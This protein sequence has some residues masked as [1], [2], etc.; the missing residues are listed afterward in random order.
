MKRFYYFPFLQ[1]RAPTNC[2]HF[3]NRIWIRKNIYY[4]VRDEY[5]RLNKY[6]LPRHLVWLWKNIWNNVGLPK[7]NFLC[8]ILVQKK[9]LTAEN[10]E[11]RDMQGS[12]LCVLCCKY[13][14]SIDH[15]FLHCPYIK[16]VWKN[17]FWTNQTHKIHSKHMGINVSNLEEQL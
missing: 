10:L 3:D 16:D 2:L 8:W 15:M 9:I 13:A 6:N 4:N 12:S 1:G 11:K 7:I 14:K 17:A 5:E